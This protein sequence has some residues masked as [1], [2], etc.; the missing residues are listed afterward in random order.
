MDQLESKTPGRR[1]RME[2][3]FSFD[4]SI[5]MEFGSPR[6]RVLAEASISVLA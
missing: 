1:W 2:P 6:P 5:R 4:I 3:R